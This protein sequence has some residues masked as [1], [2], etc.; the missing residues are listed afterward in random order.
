MPVRAD[1]VVEER[2]E[3]ELRN[4][5][6]VWLL[7]HELVELLPAQEGWDGVEAVQAA[8]HAA[9]AQFNRAILPALNERRSVGAVAIQVAPAAS[10]RLGEWLAANWDTDGGLVVKPPHDTWAV[11]TSAARK[12]SKVVGYSAYNNTLD[13][14]DRTNQAKNSLHLTREH[15]QVSACM[16]VQ[17]V[18]CVPMHLCPSAG[19]A[20]LA[21]HRLRRGGAQRAGA[22]RQAPGLPCSCPQPGR[23]C[24]AGTCT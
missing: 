7:Q 18:A 1:D 4:G 21:G 14:F 13:E 5:Q 2:F 19:A 10:L 8:V 22:N 16:C 23:G 12:L 9:R 24:C 11:M 15:L 20:G 6:V 17:R 3:V